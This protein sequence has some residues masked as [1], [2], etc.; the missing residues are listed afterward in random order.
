MAIGYILLSNVKSACTKRLAL[1]STYIDLFWCYKQIYAA[2][3][4]Y[5]FIYFHHG[6]HTA[7]AGSC[8]NVCIFRTYLL[9]FLFTEFYLKCV[10]LCNKSKIAFELYTTTMDTIDS[11]FKFQKFISFWVFCSLHVDL[12]SETCIVS[13]YLYLLLLRLSKSMWKKRTWSVNCV[14]LCVYYAIS[15][16]VCESSLGLRTYERLLAKW[17]RTFNR[18]RKTKIPQSATTLPVCLVWAVVVVYSN[19]F[20]FCFQ[21][22]IW[23]YL[24]HYGWWLD[25]LAN[26]RYWMYCSASNKKNETYQNNNWT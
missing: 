21:P 23:N 24:K 14:S 19:S 26:S 20:S 13:L 4:C 2:R 9:L 1:N 18:E 17:E 22:L 5:L 10:S 25:P 16:P 12:H 15:D 6:I 7:V 8:A 11:M 3:W